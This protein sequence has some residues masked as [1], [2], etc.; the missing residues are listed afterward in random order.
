[1][2]HLC[3]KR[4]LVNWVLCICSAF[5]KPDID[6]K[7]QIRTKPE[8]LHQVLTAFVNKPATKNVHKL[9]KISLETCSSSSCEFSACGYLLCLFLVQTFNSDHISHIGNI[10][11]IEILAEELLI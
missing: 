8:E 4:N 2:L 7:Q 1:M 10:Q 6:A 9:S 5:H 11:K 3:K